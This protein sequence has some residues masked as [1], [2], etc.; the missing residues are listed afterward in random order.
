MQPAPEASGPIIPFLPWPAD[1]LPLSVR[2]APDSVFGG[3]DT[4]GAPEPAAEIAGAFEAGPAGN[5]LDTVV[6]D[7]E[8]LRG[9]PQPASDETAHGRGM[10]AAAENAECAAFAD[11]GGGR[12]LVERE[13]PA[14]VFENIA[15]H[16]LKTRLL[17]GGAE[18]GRRRFLRK[19][20]VDGAD[21]LPETE[22]E[23]A[24]AQFTKP[25]LRRVALHIDDVSDGSDDFISGKA[26]PSVF[27]ASRRGA[28]PAAGVRTTGSGFG[29]LS[30]QQQVRMRRGDDW[31]H[32]FPVEEAS[33]VGQEGRQKEKVRNRRVFLRS[34]AVNRPGVHEHAL[35]RPGVKGVCADHAPHAAALHVQHFDF[36]MPVAVDGPQG[37][38]AHSLRIVVK[39]IFGFP[40]PD[41]LPS[42]G[43]RLDFRVK[44]IFGSHSPPSSRSKV[45]RLTNRVSDYSS[46]FQRFRFLYSAIL[47]NRLPYLSADTRAKPKYN[48]MSRDLGHMDA[49]LG[50]MN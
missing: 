22:E 19:A 39:G 9:V 5:A 21:L 37:E 41:R 46:A 15:E 47:C 27:S 26:V 36:R 8:K 40:V 6:R 7:G 29:L 43:I 1:L 20:P 30:G 23:F 12:D 13:G 10:E 11:A 17:T 42:G 14:V 2:S 35:P 31:P 18:T 25:A 28:G 34:E 3:C 45:P 49:D 48:T 44:A 24:G 16:G 38:L 50:H 33:R 4:I 32:V